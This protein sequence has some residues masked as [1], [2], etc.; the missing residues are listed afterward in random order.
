MKKEF[1]GWEP[2]KKPRHGL[3]AMERWKIVLEGI[4]QPYRVGQTTQ[5]FLLQ[6]YDRL[7]WEVVMPHI[8]TTLRYVLKVFGHS[9]F[10]F[11]SH[12]EGD[13]RLCCFRPH[14]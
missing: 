8:R 3:S 1:E 14:W 10:I 2:L 5:E 13:G 7:M 11:T 6:P 9:L 4:D 12:T